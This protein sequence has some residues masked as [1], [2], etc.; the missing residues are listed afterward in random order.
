MLRKQ[1]STLHETETELERVIADHKTKQLT[2]Q[3]EI[4]SNASKLSNLLSDIEEKNRKIRVLSEERDNFQMNMSR[5][6][7]QNKQ[8][9]AQLDQAEEDFRKA[10]R[11]FIDRDRLD[12]EQLRAANL[13]KSLER[14]RRSTQEQEQE[15]NSRNKELDRENILLREDV[16]KHEKASRDL[17]RKLHAAKSEWKAREEENQ[18]RHGMEQKLRKEKEQAL[19][20]KNR[21]LE[22][23]SECIQILSI[24]Y[25]LS[26]VIIYLQIT[27]TRCRTHE[28]GY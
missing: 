27:Q 18:S 22:A 1:A 23:E 24:L 20:M 25:S 16:E 17:N 15:L 19:A 2:Y 13:E 6:K 7:E 28:I 10:K 3:S 9:Q 12:A 8:L 11:C 21:E 5:A 4:S 14:L 26:S